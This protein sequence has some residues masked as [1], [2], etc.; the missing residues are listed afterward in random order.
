MKRLLKRGCRPKE[1]PSGHHITHK[2]TA[3]A[4]SIP[5][6]V[7]TLGNNDS[8][9][10]YLRRCAE[11]GLK[12]HPARFPVQMPEHFIKFLTDEKDLV[13][14][15][16]AGSCTTG[17]AAEKLRRRWIGIEVQPTYLDG[18]KFRFDTAFRLHYG[19]QPW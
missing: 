10:Y 19:V 5:P 8:N 16:F 13:L 14:D 4:G 7:L 2:F 3:Q 15:P 12:P 6:N 17:E 11:D 1:R 9:G 18:A